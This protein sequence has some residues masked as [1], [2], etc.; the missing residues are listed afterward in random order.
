MKAIL[1]SPVFRPTQ[2]RPPQVV[3]V[4]TTQMQHANIWYAENQSAG[5]IPLTPLVVLHADCR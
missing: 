3:P 5:E 2:T 1:H 4:V